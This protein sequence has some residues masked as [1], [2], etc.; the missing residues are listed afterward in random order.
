MHVCVY[1]REDDA[2]CKCDCRLKHLRVRQ[3]IFSPSGG[4]IPRIF[5]ADGLDDDVSQLLQAVVDAGASPLLHQGLVVH[6]FGVDGRGR[7]NLLA[8][9]MFRD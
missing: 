4:V 9:E 1:N 3:K 8:R 7:R 6:H 5:L 2:V